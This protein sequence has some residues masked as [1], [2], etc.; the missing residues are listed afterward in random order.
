MDA[1]SGAY[2]ELVGVGG[3]GSPLTED[4]K[5]AERWWAWKEDRLR[6]LVV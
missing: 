2:Y 3:L 1:Q 4:S 5:L 6:V